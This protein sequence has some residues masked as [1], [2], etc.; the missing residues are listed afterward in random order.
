MYLSLVLVTGRCGS[1]EPVSEP[2]LR[3][4]A[5]QEVGNAGGARVRSFSGVAQSDRRTE[6]SFRS[7]G[8]I[9]RL[10]VRVGQTVRKGELIAELDNVEARL[11]HE[12]AVSSLNAAQSHTTTAKLAFDR[13]RSLYEKGSSSLGDFESAKDALRSAE[14]SFESAQR[15]VDIQEEQISY[16]Y[17]YA[18]DSGTIARVLA[19]VN[20]TVSPGQSVAVLN[21]GREMEIA[22]GL[23]ESVINGVTS[24]MSVNVTLP[25]LSNQSFAAQVTEVSPSIDPE[26]A[27][28]P[29]R[30][31]VTEPSAEI[32][33][34]MAASVAFDLAGPRS[35]S[36]KLVVPA[37]AVGEDGNGR[38][39][40]VV[41]EEDEA[42]VV[43][44]R[45]VQIGELTPDGFEI[46]DGLSLGE[47]V[48]TAG[49]QTL[50][51]G[52]RVARP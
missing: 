35:S 16:G 30:I 3:P 37:K 28:Y 10:D 46:L 43:R 4:V 1:E 38:F 6:L 36:E 40:F 11:A 31:R 22:V 27:T 25:S 2:I 20:E 32:R 18:P 7:S 12:Q 9:T 19:E 49:L 5:Y 24:G 42:A 45:H 8:I 21:A 50:L 51:D 44:K 17:I 15:S 48:A 23:P 47:K 39:V 52:Q 26:A 29:V 14:A 13:V 33:A 41:E 34:G